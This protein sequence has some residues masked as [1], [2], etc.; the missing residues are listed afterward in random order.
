M[1]DTHSPLP[2]TPADLFA[3]FERLGIPVRTAEHEAV[4]TVEQS[5]GVKA[6]IPGGH[7]KN[8][9]L[10]DKKG[11]LFLVVARDETAIDLKRLHEPLGAAGRLSFGSAELL[12]QVLGVEPGSVTP[13]G[14]VNDRAGLV[15]VVLDAALMSFEEVN[16]HPLVNTM[17]TTIRRQDLVAFLEAT[18]HPPRV[19]A[20]PAPPSAAADPGDPPVAAPS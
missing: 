17:T 3:Q 14:V 18:G 4:F 19:V 7:S 15:S 2:A 13:F 12:R 5:R 6:A 11:R 20:L 8:L 16:F 9:F 10:K 1:T